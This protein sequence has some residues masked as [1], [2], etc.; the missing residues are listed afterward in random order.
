MERSALC[1]SIT[2]IHTAFVSKEP[3]PPVDRICASELITLPSR[4]PPLLIYVREPGNCDSKESVVIRENVL[5][6]KRHS[7]RN[8]RYGR[9]VP[10]WWQMNTA[11][12]A[13]FKRS[14]RGV[15]IR[16]VSDASPPQTE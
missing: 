12:G 8:Q 5:T 10:T 3:L 15:K 16:R 1:V 6:N 9:Q 11:P 14:S 4:I 13:A 7:P 2:A